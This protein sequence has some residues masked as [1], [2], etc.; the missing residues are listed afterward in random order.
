MRLID[1][2]IHFDKYDDRDITHI[3]KSSSNIYKLLSVSNDLES[4][5]RNLELSNMFPKVEAAFGYH[6]EQKLPTEKEQIDLFD[7]IHH[8]KDEMIAIGEVGLPYY[9]KQSQNVSIH[10]YDQYIELLETFVQKAADWKKPIILHAVYEDAQIVCD[11]L[12]KYSIKRA[13]FHWFKG[14]NLTIE[15]MIANGYFIS[16]PPEVVYKEKIQKLVET[17]PLDKMMIETDGPWPFEGPFLCQMTQPNMMCESIKKIAEIKKIP[18]DEVAERLFL[19]T[20]SFYHL[21]GF[22]SREILFPISRESAIIDNS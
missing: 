22:E 5:K 2:H 13:H 4:C 14:S 16:I 17:Y 19:N 15:R 20:T 12:E 6:P 3:L 21:T 9:L 7:W 18:L 10:Q 1:S 8:H 11:L